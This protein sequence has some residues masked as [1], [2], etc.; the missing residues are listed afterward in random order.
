MLFVLDN[1]EHLLEASAAVV[2]DILGSC[3]K[4]TIL[5]TSREPLMVAGE[6]NWQVPSLSLTDEA[7]ELFADRARRARPDFTVDDTT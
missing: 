2:N 1:C 4:V 6:V 5:A 3:A 7:I